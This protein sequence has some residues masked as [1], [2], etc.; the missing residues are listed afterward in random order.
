[1]LTRI[2]R[3]EFVSIQCQCDSDMSIKNIYSVIGKWQDCQISG[4]AEGES[5]LYKKAVLSQR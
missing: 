2:L 1:M 3:Y 4:Y 5:K